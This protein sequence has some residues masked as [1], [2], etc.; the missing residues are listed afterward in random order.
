MGSHEK[1]KD[2]KAD[3]GPQHL[4]QVQPIWMCKFEV[5]CEVYD[6][7][8]DKK[9]G[10]H[11][12]DQDKLDAYVTRPTPPYTDPTF[13]YGRIGNPALNITHHAAM[14]FCRWLSAKTGK[15]YRLPTEA[16]WEWACRAGTTT[17]YSWGDDPSK[18]DDFAW[19]ED[20]SEEK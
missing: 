11:K 9:I 2:R 6:L 7:F 4:A 17:A 18:V 3:E 1:E 19:W 14:K 5:P 16:E 13:G 10:A 8:W 20:N 15:T 12:P